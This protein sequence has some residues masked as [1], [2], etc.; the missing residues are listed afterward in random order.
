MKD[1]GWAWVVA[2]TAVESQGYTAALRIESWARALEDSKQGLTDALFLAFWTEERLQWYEY[3]V[4]I[5]QIESGLFKLKERK[6]LAFNGDLKALK[7]YEIGVCRG[8]AIADEFDEVDYLNK[9]TQKNTENGLKM[10]F[11]KRLDFVA[12]NRPTAEIL[13]NKLEPAYKGISQKI[14]FIKPALQ[15]NDLLVGISKKAPDYKK[16][17]RDFNRGMKQLFLDGTYHKIQKQYGF[18]Q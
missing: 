15:V 8:C 6:D 5:A 17:L 12:A 18:K 14:I 13:L 1:L 11:V 16:K 7:P 3:T 10:L 9:V 4:P 2:K